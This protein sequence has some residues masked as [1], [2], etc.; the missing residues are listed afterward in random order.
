MWREDIRGGIAAQVNLLGRADG[1]IGRNL[2]CAFLALVDPLHRHYCGGFI[3]GWRTARGLDGLDR[4]KEI[5]KVAALG[6][7]EEAFTPGPNL[8]LVWWYI[9]CR[10][11]L[12]LDTPPDE[13]HRILL[14]T[15]VC[16]D[17]EVDREIQRLLPLVDRLVLT[18]DL[19]LCRQQ[20]DVRPVPSQAERIPTR[21]RWVR[22]VETRNKW[23]LTE[24]GQAELDRLLHVD[25]DDLACRRV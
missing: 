8:C 12:G 20:A 9:E 18:A 1:F 15:N 16:T 7:P 14:G 5:A 13:I 10:A 23:K 6:Y 19:L 11:R 21:D 24:E 17:A 4:A 2:D 3:E 25:L 22:P